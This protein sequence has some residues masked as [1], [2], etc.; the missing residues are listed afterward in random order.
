[1]LAVY[2]H[3]VHKLR[4]RSH[5]AAVEEVAGKIVNE[6]V[7]RG[8]DADAAMLSRPRGDQE[9]TLPA[10]ES[11]F[12]LS[13]LTGETVAAQASVDKFQDA[14]QDLVTIENPRAAHVTWLESDAAAM[15]NEAVQYPYTSLKYHVLVAAALLSNYRAGAA[16]DELSLVVDDSKEA[17]TPYRTVLNTGPV[18]LRLTADPG[19]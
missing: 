19:D 12:R 5:A 2:R 8:A 17:V 18:S 4:G 14:V 1:M 6:T 15:F 10:H 3:D 13:L 9:Q 7:P 16:F 11:P